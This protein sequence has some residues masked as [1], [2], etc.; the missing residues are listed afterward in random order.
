MLLACSGAKID[1]DGAKTMKTQ[2]DIDAKTTMTRIWAVAAASGN[3]H[4]AG[5]TKVAVAA[6]SGNSH[7]AISSM[8]GRI[9]ISSC[10]N[11]GGPQC[12]V[13]AS[14]QGKGPRRRK[15]RQGERRCGH[16]DKRVHDKR[17]CRR[18]RSYR[19]KRLYLQNDRINEGGHTTRRVY[20]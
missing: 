17:S 7:R 20:R 3:S 10:F 16:I 9:D 19:Q 2:N 1:N 12:L 15:V 5:P 8:T 13:A 6:T 11:K 14:M 18:R 4:Q